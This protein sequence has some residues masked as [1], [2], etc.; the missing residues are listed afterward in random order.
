MQRS[1]NYNRI[2]VTLGEG[3]NYDWVGH[4]EERLV[5]II[6]IHKHK[7]KNNQR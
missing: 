7:Y 2:I 1:D 4:M 6:Y 5:Y 3:K